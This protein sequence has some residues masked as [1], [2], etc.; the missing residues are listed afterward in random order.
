M[1]PYLLLLFSA[2]IAFSSCRKIKIKQDAQNPD[3]PAYSEKGL[4][5]GG[6]LINNQA[7]LVL[8]PG[9]MSTARPFQLFSFPSGDSIVV[10]LNGNFKDTALQN[11]NL[12]TIFVVIKNIKIITDEDLLQLNN[13]SFILDGITNYGGFSDSYGENKK[14]SGVGK[15]SFGKVSEISNI[16]YGNGTAGNPTLHPYIISGKLNMDF[17]TNKNYSLTAGRFDMNIMRNTPEF[18]VF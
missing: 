4:N 1:K 11:Q 5:A 13:R 6:I 18:I 2:L 8:K 9:F 17:Y 10:L 14:G 12:R 3:L 7:W 15:L 16:T